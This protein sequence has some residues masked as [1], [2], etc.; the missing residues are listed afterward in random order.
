MSTFIKKFNPLEMSE[1]EI[2]G[3]ATGREK[4]LEIMLQEMKV[5]L[6]KGSNQHFILYGPRGIGKSFFT[7]LLKIHHDRSE[8][9][10]DSTFIQLPEEQDNINFA[11]DLLDVISIILEGGKLVDAVPRWSILPA[12]W[13]ASVKR[14]RLALEQVKK[15]K[16]I[17]HVFITQE[18]LQVFIPKLDTIESTR[19]REFLSDFDEITIIGSSL[20]PDLDNDYSKRLF[21]VYKK[22]DLEPWTSQDFLN[23]YEKIANRSDNKSDQLEKIKKSKN[24]IKAISKF[25]GG[26]PRLAVILS[27]LILDKNILETAKLL[28]GII[29]E[30]TT[31]YQDITNDIPQKSKILFDMLIRKG[32]NITQSNLAASFVPPIEQSTIARSF[33]W[34]LD[35]YYVIQSKQSKGNTKYFYVRDRLYVLYYQKRQIYHDVPFS[36]VG[37]FVDFLNEFYTQ[38][39]RLEELKKLPLDH[40]YSKPL[41]YNFAIKENLLFP[42]EVDPS[43]LKEIII[44]KHEVNADQFKNLHL[45]GLYY[46]E[47]KEFERAIQAYLNAIKLKPDNFKAYYNLGLVYAELGEYGNEIQA[48]IKALELNPD[49]IEADYNLGNSYLKLGENDKAIQTFQKVLNSNPMDFRAMLNLGIAYGNLKEFDKAIQTLQK[50]IEINPND[51]TG[52]HNLGSYY[53]LI[54]DYNNAISAITKAIEI[55][56]GMALSYNNLGNTNRLISD[57]NEAIANYQKALELEPKTNMFLS[58]FIFTIITTNDWQKMKQFYNIWEGKPS[59]SCMIGESLY[60]YIINLINNKFFYFRN[61][62]NNIKDFDFINIYEVINSLFIGLYTYKESSLLNQIIEEL[63]HDNSDD[64]ILLVNLQVYKYLLNPS[65]FDIN[66]LHPDARAVV[67]S[68]LEVEKQL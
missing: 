15:E 12:Q 52:Y 64:Q 5:C 2:L 32:E 30:L 9:F 53:G 19:L 11:S 56:P 59:F 68:I 25:T 47:K 16:G 57:N 26:S 41:L 44:S 43:L 60:Q 39:E 6:K 62:F 7:R 35:N 34:L 63:E 51:N 27:Q 45:E 50:A 20:R 1:D 31:Y 33:S 42:E 37:V 40:E 14:L 38:K 61:T 46:Y 66:Q 21:Q 55:N 18:N 67:E 36:F 28:D 17:K 23:Y 8:N 48:Y 49:F 10:K 24:K 58:N 13:Q 4:L 3:L 65:G 29:D 22:L 54:G